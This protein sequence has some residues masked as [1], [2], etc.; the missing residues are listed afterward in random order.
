MLAFAATEDDQG[1]VKKRRLLSTQAKLH[2]WNL[3]HLVDD[4]CS[5]TKRELSI[6]VLFVVCSR[7]VYN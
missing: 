2:M 1:A 4:G 5:Y 3:I 6:T 7:E